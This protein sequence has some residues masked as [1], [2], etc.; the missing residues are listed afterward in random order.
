MT[1][2]RMDKIVRPGL[3]EASI[4][5]WALARSV[6]YKMTAHDRYFVGVKLLALLEIL[7]QHYN[8]VMEGAKEPHTH[9][10]NDNPQHPF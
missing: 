9:P 7:E 8:L 10:D 2:R 1:D 6:N 5:L 3:R 4:D